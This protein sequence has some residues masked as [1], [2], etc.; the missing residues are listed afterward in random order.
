[1]RDFRENHQLSRIER[2]A[3][4]AIPM[5]DIVPFAKRMMSRTNSSSFYFHLLKTPKASRH[6]MEPKA[7]AIPGACSENDHLPIRLAPDLLSTGCD[8]GIYTGEKFEGTF[9]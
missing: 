9:L 1:M 3:V 4:S 8:T 6:G 2:E 7:R 5:F